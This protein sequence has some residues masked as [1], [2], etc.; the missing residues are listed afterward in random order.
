MADTERSALIVGVGAI[1]GL[2]AAYGR[3]FAKAGYRV[4]LAGRTL[5]KVEAAAE[6]ICRA[7]GQAQAIIGDASVEEDAVRFATEAE[8]W[9]PI[10]VAVHNAGTNRRDSFLDLEVANLEQLWREHT[11]GAFLTGREAARR[12]VPRGRGTIIFTGASGSLRGKAL[13]AAFASAKAGVRALSQSLAREVGPKGV[14]VAHLII[15]G[16]IDGARLLAAMPNLREER[17][18]DG[19]LD[20][21][22]IA[23]TAFQVHGQH[24]SAW[25]Q[26]VDLRP[27]AEAF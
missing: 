10:D 17:G 13:F 7:G 1:A 3:R 9:G 4:T 6:D 22:A 12:M 11:L 19:L 26:E 23:E 18:Q 16:G 27:W 14:H 20:P 25:T 8:K 15:D 2:G 24:R 21:D 5:E